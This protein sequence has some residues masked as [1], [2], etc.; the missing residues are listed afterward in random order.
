MRYRYTPGYP[1]TGP[2]YDSGG[3]PGAGAE[4][5]LVSAELVDGDGLDPR[6]EQVMDWAQDWL[7]SDSGYAQAC[8]AAEGEQGP[9]PDD[10]RDQ[11]RERDADTWSG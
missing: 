8:A 4:V 3:E 7:D 9:Y 1:A 11:K 6:Q 2:S 5:E 10:L